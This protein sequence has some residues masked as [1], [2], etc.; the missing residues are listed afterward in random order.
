MGA[1]MNPSKYYEDHVNDIELQKALIRH[2]SNKISKDFILSM[3]NELQNNSKK[4]PWLDWSPN[5]GEWLWEVIYHLGKLQKAIQKGDT[6]KVREYSA[7]LG[8]YA[9]KAFT[10]WGKNKK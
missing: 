5:P 4:G 2:F 1:Q 9:E 10:L 6:D 3:N 8:N 7:D